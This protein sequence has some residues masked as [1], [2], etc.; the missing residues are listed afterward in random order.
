MNTTVLIRKVKRPSRHGNMSPKNFMIPI[1][2][3]YFGRQVKVIIEELPKPQSYESIWTK[4]EEYEDL[5]TEGQESA[6]DETKAIN[7]NAKAII[8]DK[9]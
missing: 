2:S 9:Q 6:L 3:Q 7:Q 4:P 5:L 8:G 1:P